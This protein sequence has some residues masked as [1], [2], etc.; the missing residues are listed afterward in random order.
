[1]V[2]SMKIEGLSVVNENSRLMVDQSVMM[3]SASRMLSLDE[4]SLSKKRRS[5]GICA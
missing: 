5:S 2:V 4:K 1:M 3:V